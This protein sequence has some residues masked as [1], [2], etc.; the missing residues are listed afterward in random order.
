MRNIRITIEKGEILLI[1]VSK[2]Y[3]SAMN[4]VIQC[5]YKM[6][7]LNNCIINLRI[8]LLLSKELVLKA[9]RAT[10]TKAVTLFAT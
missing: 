7:S 3:N 2:R 5:I 6:V 4:S 9:L 1:L 10:Q 8:L